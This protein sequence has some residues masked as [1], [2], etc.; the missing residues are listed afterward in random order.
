[1]TLP[2]A[3]THP[4]EK[5]TAKKQTRFP[6]RLVA[7]VAIGLVVGLAGSLNQI[8]GTNISLAIPLVAEG[9]GPTFN[10]LDS[11]EITGAQTYP[12]SGNL[13]MVTVALRTNMSTFQALERWVTTKDTFYPL[14]AL[15][16]AGASMDEIQ[17]QNSQEFA[18]S[19]NLATVAA[20]RYLNRPLKVEI[21]KV[22]PGSPAENL[23]QVGD[24]LTKVDGVELT[25]S[26]QLATYISEHQNSTLQ[27]EGL[28]NGEPFQVAVTITDRLNVWLTN[29]SDV[30]INYGLQDVGGPSAGMMFALSVIDKLTPEALTGGKFIA[31]TGTIT[32]D[33]Q[34]GPIGGI[35]HKIAS[36]PDAEAFLVPADNCKEALKTKTKATLI[37]V[38]TLAEAVTAVEHFAAAQPVTTCSAAAEN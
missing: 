19:E 20:M 4:D 38:N 26:D 35:T 37:K 24:I 8:P 33:G 16:P 18:D 23:L 32:A 14:S 10:T 5:E 27:L 30:E 6:K 21:A 25:D 17:E 2:A 34:V 29:Q 31:G 3:E 12:T 1:M 9:P 36:V 13:N 7:T 22:L 15:Y 28:R 11:T